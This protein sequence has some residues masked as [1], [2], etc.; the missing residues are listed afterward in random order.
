MLNV[1]FT[2]YIKHDLL[3]LFDWLGQHGYDGC[4]QIIMQQLCLSPEELARWREARDSGEGVKA[5]Q[6]KIINLA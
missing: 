6:E 4:T 5:L 1:R 2:A 3:L